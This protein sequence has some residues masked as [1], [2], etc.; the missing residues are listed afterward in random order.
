MAH[1]TDDEAYQLESDKADYIY[2]NAGIRLRWSFISPVNTVA[3]DGQIESLW[4][5]MY[6]WELGLRA[7]CGNHC[8]MELLWYDRGA[9][10]LRERE[11]RKE[12][13]Q[14]T[15]LWLKWAFVTFLV[16]ICWTWPDITDTNRGEQASAW[17]E[18]SVSE[19]MLL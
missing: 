9:A 4:D 3:H 17:G 18:A 8:G 16:F 12:L 13:E 14:F 6:Q 5:Y 10:I 19:A 7:Q 11:E 1:V 2:L 15:Q